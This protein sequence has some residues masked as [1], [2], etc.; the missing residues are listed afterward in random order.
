MGWLDGLKKAPTTGYPSNE[1][2]Q[3]DNSMALAWLINSMEAK[4]SQNLILCDIAKQ[5]WDTVNL[6]YSNLNND[7]QLYDLRRFMRLNRQVSR[8]HLI[9]AS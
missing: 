7:S 1:A 8:L 2:W 3:V 9:L 6:M 5:L 4:V